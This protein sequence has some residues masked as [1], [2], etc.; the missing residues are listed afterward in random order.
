MKITG[1]ELYKKTVGQLR[2][3]SDGCK[4]PLVQFNNK[5]RQKAFQPFMQDWLVNDVCQELGP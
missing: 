1:S 3:S 4:S 2:K 5:P